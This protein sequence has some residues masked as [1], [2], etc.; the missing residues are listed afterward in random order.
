MASRAT[1]EKRSGFSDEP[2]GSNPEPPARGR[3][4][5]AYSL[6]HRRG[7]DWSKAIAAGYKY[8]ASARLLLLLGSWRSRISAR[9]V[10]RHQ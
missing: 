2:R 8:T 9:A 4:R 5:D 6:A 1:R 10:A 7:V 3:S